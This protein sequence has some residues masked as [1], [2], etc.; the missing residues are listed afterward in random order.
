MTDTSPDGPA[1]ESEWT[2]LQQ[3]LTDAWQRTGQLLDRLTSEV[4]RLSAL[5]GELA[6][7]DTPLPDPTPGPTPVVGWDDSPI[8]DGAETLVA[9]SPDIVD[10]LDYSGVQQ[11][12][13][14]VNGAG[15]PF[16]LSPSWFAPTRPQPSDG[17]AS[18][19]GHNAGDEHGFDIHMSS[20]WAPSYASTSVWE[21]YLPLTDNVRKGYK[22]VGM[23]YSFQRL[24]AETYRTIKLGGGI[25]MFPDRTW[26]RWP[27]GNRNAGPQNASMRFVLNADDGPSH[28]PRSAAYMYLE[29][30]Q[31][32]RITGARDPRLDIDTGDGSRFQVVDRNGPVIAHGA[33][34]QH[35]YDVLVLCDAGEAGQP[36][37]SMSM[38]V[39]DRT[40]G[41]PWELTMRVDRMVWARSGPCEFTTAYG[42]THYGG[43]GPAFIPDGGAGSVRLTG[44]EWFTW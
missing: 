20:A 31:Q 12:A 14:W 41:D 23:R 39:R 29:N 6:D 18:M 11:A 4:G 37:G 17:F 24:S 15:E 40:A 42:C 26:S 30:E 13:L 7:P 2:E 33:R 19:Y 9:M 38:Y 27:G 5:V 25:V 22:R 1:T 43:K 16:P 34:A 8:P 32:P 10:G 36:D 28:L 44:M 21:Q 35:V 3:E